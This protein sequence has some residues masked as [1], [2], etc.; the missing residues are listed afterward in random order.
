M[1]RLI[2]F[3]AVAG[4]I[5]GG[6]VWDWAASSQP[7]N[8]FRTAKVERGRLVATI[9]ATGTV[10]P[11]EV[12]DVGAQVAGRI[13]YLGADPSDPKKMVQW[14]SAVEGPVLND[15]GEVIKK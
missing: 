10:E 1:K 7:R 9:G 14:G 2:I 5:A 12:V 3:L 8:N 6:G 4:I 13:E 11:E 15:K